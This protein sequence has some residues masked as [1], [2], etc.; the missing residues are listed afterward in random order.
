MFGTALPA[1]IEMIIRLAE[2]A[3]KE[4][5]EVNAPDTTAIEKEGARAAERIWR[6]LFD[7]RQAGAA[8]GAGWRPR[9]RSRRVSRPKARKGGRAEPAGP[10]AA[11]FKKLEAD[12]VRNSILDTGAASTAATE[13]RAADRG[14]GRRLR[15]TH[16]SAVFTRGRDAG[17]VVGRSHRRDEQYIDACRDL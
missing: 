12:I 17:L 1:V 6:R 14:G 11:V 4:P 3:A 10:V 9:P 2:K 13:D 7:P 16:G 15:R 5:R 8:Q